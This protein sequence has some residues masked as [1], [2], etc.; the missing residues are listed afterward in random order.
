MSLPKQEQMTQTISKLFF[1]CDTCENQ[2]EPSFRLLQQIENDI[3]TEA[4]FPLHCAQTMRLTIMEVMKPAPIV[5]VPIPSLISSIK[6]IVQIFVEKQGLDRD[7]SDSFNRE[8]HK[9]L[10]EHASHIQD[11]T[12]AVAEAMKL[13]IHPILAKVPELLQF[14]TSL[15][16]LLLE[17][18]E[19]SLNSA[20]NRQRQYLGENTSR[21]EG[22]MPM[23]VDKEVIE[24]TSVGIDCGTSTTHLIFS[25]LT[26]QRESGFLNM[27]RRY[28]IVNRE[29]I[30]ESTIVPTP[31]IDESTIDFDEVINFVKAQYK[32]ANLKLTDIDSGAVIVTGE[33]AKKNNAPRIVEQISQDA[34]KFVSATAGPN[35]ESL[36]AAHGSG[37]VK[38]SEQLQS[39]IL[40]VDIGGGTSNLAISSKGKVIET[41]CINV[42]GRLLGITEDRIIWRLEKPILKVMKLLGLSYKVNDQIKEEHLDL[43][44][45]SLVD[46]LINVMTG[47]ANSIITQEL[48]M[49]EPLKFTLPIDEIIFSGGVA[50]LIY[51]DGKQFYNDIA[52]LIAAK[53]KTYD[54]NLPVHEPKHKIRATVIGAGSYSVAISGSTCFYDP[55][56]HLPLTNLLVLTI[57]EQ[58]IH[59]RESLQE[60]VAKANRKY[61]ISLDTQVVAYY[62]P[63]FPRFLHSIEAGLEQQ[64]MQETRDLG[65]INFAKNFSSVLSPAIDKQMPIVVVFRED[66][67]GTLG[68]FFPEHTDLTSNF[69]FIDELSLEEG[70]YIDIGLAIKSQEVFPIIIKS[71][72]FNE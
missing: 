56:L 72:A 55:K 10:D 54:F 4:D 71:L 35:F 43:V 18:I 47:S 1:V 48:M 70:D 17:T 7:I 62:F 22:I 29:I 3:A 36:L 32:L 44:A 53:L 11:D 58:D 28:N 12:F 14:Q 37:A 34:G 38:R 51:Q 15:H 40:S 46:A 16:H 25:K 66:M 21:E 50:E 63:E 2:E 52:H 23:S 39:T 69:L 42:G 31:L 6:G 33:T 59:T 19:R 67:A 8:F 49:T 13:S 68:R 30:Y 61:D 5:E 27:T 45:Q 64:N 60:A 20:R 65:F 24:M 26:L 41:A 57:P 9:T